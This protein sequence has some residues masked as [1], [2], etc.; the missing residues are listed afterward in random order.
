MKDSV[1]WTGA[2][3][4]Q[5]LSVNQSMPFMA[6]GVS[7]DSRTVAPGDLFIALKGLSQ[8]GHDYVG[9]AFEK[10]AVAA[11]VSEMP[12]GLS[13]SFKDKLLWVTETQQALEALGKAAR[14]RSQAKIIAITGSVGKTG[15]KEALNYVL[16]SQ[17]LTTANVLSYN[18]QWG[19]PL[20]LAR[21]PAAAAYGIFEVGMNHPGE[22]TPLTQMI[23]PHVALITTVVGAHQE[24]FSSVEEIALA[25]AE[26]FQGLLPEGTAILNHDNPYF[27]F[28]REK[29]QTAGVRQIISFGF[30]PQ[31][32]I[33]G[34]TQDLQE[35]G[36]QVH[37]LIHGEPLA[38]RLS[39]PGL[40][41]VFNSLALVAVLVALDLPPGRCVDRLA[42]LPPL[43]GRGKRHLLTYNGKAFTLIDESYNANPA[44]M[45]AALAV[46]GKTTP[47]GTGRRIAILGDMRELGEKGPEAH[48]ALKPLL[49]QHR[50][51]L[52]LTCGPLMAQL[53]E[54]LP[55][56]Q[57]GF[58]AE[59]AKDLLSPLQSVLQAGDV[60]MV[61]GSNRL[62]LG[63]IVQHFLQEG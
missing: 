38:Y 32:D 30:H 63:A 59:K 16:S 2:E 42:T 50:V 22:I 53:Y 48:L 37:A 11:L 25:K 33:R 12:Q 58:S 6:T 14:D 55:F 3:L 51:D 20:S 9:M 36:A 4:T 15:T 31:A 35:D 8:N 17:G 52:V 57:Q 19:V 56:S 26:I 62:D 60:V 18:N 10:G 41:W 43:K 54:A 23:A 1:L 29:A 47:Q 21:L 13:D 24:F 7:I 28:L 49:T 5:I 27:D 40:H 45:E 34:K 46:L 44:S 39:H 61:K